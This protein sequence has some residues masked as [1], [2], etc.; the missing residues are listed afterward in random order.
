VDTL[1][2]VLILVALLVIVL[3]GL[4]FGN[5]KLANHISVLEQT[6][7]TKDESIIYY[8]QTYEAAREAVMKDEEKEQNLQ[9][10]HQ[11]IAELTAQRDELENKIQHKEIKIFDLESAHKDVVEEVTE[12]IF[13]IEKAALER[14][15]EFE[16]NK[17]DFLLR[18]D[19][20][21]EDK[22]GLKK[23]LAVQKKEVFRHLEVLNDLNKDKTLLEEELVQNTSKH[24]MS[25][26]KMEQAHE[27]VIENV[28]EQI[29]VLEKNL[30][31]KDSNISK[32][33]KKNEEDTL[34][35]QKKLDVYETSLLE[36]QSKCD[37]LEEEHKQ[38]VKEKNQEIR[39]LKD[40]IISQ[41]KT[42]QELSDRQ[43]KK[44]FS[45]ENKLIL[46]TEKYAKFEQKYSKDLSVAKKK[47]E[48]LYAELE[49]NKSALS[50]YKEESI[51]KV[52]LLEK[53]LEL[54]NKSIKDISQEY[55]KYKVTS[56]AKIKT[57]IA[58]YETLKKD[59][60]ALKIEYATYQ[61]KKD[62]QIELLE[63]RLNLSELKYKKFKEEQSIVIKEFESKVEEYIHKVHMQDEALLNSQK[64]KEE[65]DV[66]H[67][68]NVLA[69][70]NSLSQV[71]EKYDALKEETSTR[72]TELEGSIK[73]R[74]VE[75]GKLQTQM[76]ALEIKYQDKITSLEK[77]MQNE[78]EKHT[79]EQ[80][81][82]QEKFEATIN[83]HELEIAK[84]M[85][86][87]ESEKN[88]HAVMIEAFE[89]E[90]KE[91]LILKNKL[92]EELMNMEI[93]KKKLIGTIEEQNEKIVTLIKIHEENMHKKQDQV[94]KLFE[95]IQKFSQ[96][97]K[98]NKADYEAL[99][100]SYENT[101]SDLA[102][103]SGQ[104]QEEGQ[105]Q[106]ALNATF[107]A[108]KIKSQEMEENHIAYQEE[109]AML[110]EQM[111]EAKNTQIDKLENERKA[112]A[113]LHAEMK[114]SEKKAADEKEKYDKKI[115]ESNQELD[116]VI[117]SSALKDNEIDKLMTEK[118]KVE[119]TLKEHIEQSAKM[120]E[121]FKLELDL[122][123]EDKKTLDEKFSKMQDENQSKLSEMN[124]LLKE[125]EKVEEE[126]TRTF[127]S[128]KT[129][130]QQREESNLKYKN[131]QAALL[132]EMTKE[133][134][135]QENKL[136]EERKTLAALRLEIDNEQKTIVLKEN[137]IKKLS[138]EVSRIGDKAVQEVQALESEL[139]T[140]NIQKANAE[141][142]LQL[143]MIQRNKLLKEQ[144]KFA[145]VTLLHNEKVK[146]LELSISKHQQRVGS[147]ED[148]NFQK[149]KALDE[150]LSELESVQK[151]NNEILLASKEER[152]S[153]LLKHNENKANVEMEINTLTLELENKNVELEK[154]KDMKDNSDSEIAHL[155]EMFQT[156]LDINEQNIIKFK[157]KLES[158]HETIAKLKASKEYINK[159]IIHGE[160]LELLE[161][162][163]KKKKIAKK[164]DL[165]VM[166][167][168][169]IIAVNKP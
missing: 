106:E 113:T 160:V 161:K 23:E 65:N 168:D 73:E 7:E 90:K 159:P 76:S 80:H 152:E 43:E 103:V 2:I 59:D 20:L 37:N 85:T 124:K 123:L 32:L 57:H 94:S 40:S 47:E 128:Y 78:K 19:A 137:E 39:D 25:M 33:E 77:R 97:I 149:S 5:K 142:Q 36:S 1:S 42:S 54:K 58:L 116:S 96:I 101:Q 134:E 98:R 74:D 6:I 13:V 49:E 67:K 31:L 147:L 138:D 91:N 145:N 158:K 108:Y 99:T 10:S 154:L 150:I 15:Q 148:E 102:S 155:R 22:K 130:S 167:I 87:L 112:L 146:Q 105:K 86:N 71:Y 66:R 166:D 81:I 162:G 104:L 9:K 164:F 153:L 88:M 157:E 169:F 35:N 121:N 109:Q 151:N 89:K 61:K 135:I 24:T 117:Q 79:H 119:L 70:E 165:S 132:F 62:E 114:V 55:E 68:G 115:L 41:K 8:M 14:E 69:L 83:E 21:E 53:T 4:N 131:K 82:V 56:E 26:K 17:Q 18:V 143:E 27:K 72:T 60:E 16:I 122:V 140:L 84:V 11:K 120:M 163:V 52:S 34:Q 3:V 111:E 144:E 139:K 107:E 156:Q 133:K 95:E 64:E 44:I 93:E 92:E 136:E 100:R 29:F 126:L 45:L 28:T 50:A 12:K 141:K 63:E 51:N 30:I 38:F 110:L 125:K 129:K 46:E 48:A 127:D 118:N 75:I